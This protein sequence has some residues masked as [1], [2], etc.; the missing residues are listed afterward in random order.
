MHAKCPHDGPT[1]DSDDELIGSRRGSKYH[2]CNN[3][4]HE[5]YDEIFELLKQVEEHSKQME[6]CATENRKEALE[7]AQKALKSYNAL[8]ERILHAIVNIGGNSG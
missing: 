4:D 3:K 6:L 8:S 5:K 1:N 2:R 7:Q